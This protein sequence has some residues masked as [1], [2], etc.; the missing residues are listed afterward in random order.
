M[1]EGAD[2]DSEAIVIAYG[3]NL[4]S[5]AKSSSQ[6]F[7]EV[8][9]ALT[10]HSLIITKIS[11]LWRSQAWPNAQDPAYVNAILVIRTQLQPLDLMHVLHGFER[12]AGRRRDAQLNAP[13]VLDLDLI[14]Y[15]REVMKGELVLPHPRAHERAF[16]MGPLAEVMPGWVHPVS[17]KA[18]R[19]L[20]E[21]APVGRDAYPLEPAR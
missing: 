14:A 10:G 16:V 11:R 17:G 4:S 8:V 5:G 6:A 2:G 19:E 13:R 1:E 21:S 3:S 12:D 20:Y 9:K 18:A 7:G 15:G